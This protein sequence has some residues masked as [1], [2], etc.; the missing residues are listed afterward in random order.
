MIFCHCYLHS[1]HIIWFCFKPNGLQFIVKTF[2]CCSGEN[3]KDKR[4]VRDTPT[5][6]N[7]YHKLQSVVKSS[8]NNYKVYLVILGM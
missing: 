1:L 7:Y 4:N 2:F 3:E 8:Y 6:S 5:R